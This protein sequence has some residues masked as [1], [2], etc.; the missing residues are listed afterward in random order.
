[1]ENLNSIKLNSGQASQL[2]GVSQSTLR[3]WQR[4]GR[5]K[6][7]TRDRESAWHRFTLAD[8]EEIRKVGGRH[9]T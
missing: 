8:I 1:M 7:P 2:L 3:R 5:I 9:G 6:L 4:E